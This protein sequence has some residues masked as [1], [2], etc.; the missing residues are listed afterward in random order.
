MTGVQAH[1]LLSGLEI[2]ARS[3]ESMVT[4]ALALGAASVVAIVSTSY[5]RPSAVRMRLA[6]LMFLPGWVLLGASIVIGNNIA[7]RWLAAQ[8]VND[9]QA[10][11]IADLINRDYLYQQNTLMWGLAVFAA[12]LVMYLMWWIFSADLDKHTKR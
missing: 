8:F 4:W 6:Y 11:V 3:S 7:R 5:F 9:A 12:W 2:V 10:H 1:D